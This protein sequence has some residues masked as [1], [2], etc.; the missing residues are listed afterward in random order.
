[1]CGKFGGAKLLM[2]HSVQ[3]VVLV[4]CVWVVLK[5]WSI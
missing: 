2:Y 3:D 5:Q 4:V 1:M